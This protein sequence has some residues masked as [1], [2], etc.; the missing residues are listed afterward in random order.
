MVKTKLL[1]VGAL[2]TLATSA[3][4]APPAGIETFAVQEFNSDFTQFHIGDTV[5]PMYLTDQ[6]DIKQWQLR[7]LPQPDPG[8]HWTYMGGY[9][10]QVTDT[11]GKI[12]KAYN[13][14]IFYHR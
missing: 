5:P 4:A 8:T 2:L 6:Y 7:N 11:E 13:G 9:Y 3:L 1:L 12:L 14:D 10:A